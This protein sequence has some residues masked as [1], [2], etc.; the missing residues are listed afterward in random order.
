MQIKA[1]E[2][3][4]VYLTESPVA[5]LQKEF[6]EIEEPLCTDI[7]FHTMDHL[8]TTL[9]LTAS[10]VPVEELEEFPVHFFELLRRIVDEEDIDMQRMSTVIEKEMLKVMQSI[11]VYRQFC[12]LTSH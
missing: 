6:V 3:L 9:I 2:V 8:K 1:L 12:T 11:R 10:N 7:D 5:V 4:D